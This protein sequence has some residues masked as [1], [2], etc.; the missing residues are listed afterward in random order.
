MSEDREALQQWLFEEF[1]SALATVFEGM[2]FARPEVAWEAA[3]GP[4]EATGGAWKQPFPP[5]PGALLVAVTDADA[6]ASGR[7]ILAAAG[8]E[9]ASEEELRS[10]YQETLG[11]TLGSIAR[12]LTG[13]LQKEVTSPTGAVSAEP[14][15]DGTVWAT[16][17]VTLGGTAAVWAVG[18]EPDLLEPLLAPPELPPEETA[19]DPEPDPPPPSTAVVTQAAEP[20]SK[21]FD[22]LLDVEMPVSVSFGHAK[23]ALKDVLKLTTGSI[24]ELERGIAEPVDVVVNNCVVARGEVVVVEGN[25]GVRIQEVVSRHERLRT[26][27]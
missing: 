23:L 17:R 22:L 21:T 25:F 19:A 26:L 6:I 13:K 7:H 10:T 27:Q 2:A 11:Q 20:G 8:V 1:A 15:A 16:V 9:D 4:P 14:P 18:I 24:V 12:K 5:L 3:D